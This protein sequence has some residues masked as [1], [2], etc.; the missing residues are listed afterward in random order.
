M[1]KADMEAWTIFSFYSNI[2]VN[3]NHAGPASWIEK[4]WFLSFQ[5]SQ[6]VFTHSGSSLDISILPLDNEKDGNC[7][8]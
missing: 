2:I 4:T 6:E 3:V 1:R 7:E 8:L 5:T